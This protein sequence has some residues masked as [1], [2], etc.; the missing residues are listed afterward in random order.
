MMKMDGKSG[1]KGS[2]A[3]GMFLPRMIFGLFKGR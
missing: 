2:Y 3:A 1:R